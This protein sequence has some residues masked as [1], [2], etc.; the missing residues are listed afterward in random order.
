MQGLCQMTSD[1]F[2]EPAQVIRLWIHECERTL[3]D[4]MVNKTDLDRFQDMRIKTTKKYFADIPE[5]WLTEAWDNIDSEAGASSLKAKMGFLWYVQQSSV[6]HD[7]PHRW[8]L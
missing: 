8:W 5:V 3:A 4:R 7:L 2:K 6:L 1:I